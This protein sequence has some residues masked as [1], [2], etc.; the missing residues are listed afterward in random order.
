M[1]NY[2]SLTLEYGG[3]NDSNTSWRSSTALPITPGK[4]FFLNKQGQIVAIR[5]LVN[6]GRSQ[7]PSFTT[8]E[9]N[10]IVSFLH[11]DVYA[12]IIKKAKQETQEKQ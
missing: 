9:K 12:A 7:L 10:Q 6:E 4:Y 5:E 11:A 3:S 2:V 8:E 1:L